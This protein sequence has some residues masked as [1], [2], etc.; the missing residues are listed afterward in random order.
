MRRSRRETRTPGRY[1]IFS[2]N[3]GRTPSNA[4]RI[5]AFWSSVSGSRPVFTWRDVADRSRP[6]A[7]P[8]IRMTFFAASSIPP[9]SFSTN[10]TLD[11]EPPTADW[12]LLFTKYYQLEPYQY[13]VSGVLQNKNVTALQVNGVPTADAGWTSAPFNTEIN[14]LGSD[15]KDY[16]TNLGAYSIVTDTTYFVKDIPGN[17]WK[18]VFTGY[19]GSA[20]GD[21]S[22]NQELVSSVGV[23]ELSVQQGS[24]ITYPNPVSNGLAQLIVDVPAHEGT[25]RV[26]SAT[27][28]QMIQQQWTGLSGL[29]ARTIDVSGLAKGMYIVRFDAANTST[30]GKLVIE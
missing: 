9:W 17:I 15:W 29:N 2:T 3:L 16:D 6:S 20:N 1:S 11:R 23:H 21:M 24:L 4:S 5:A 27:G 30:N 8:P 22:F 12:D 7:V 13:Y 28:Q 25:I 18:I 10:A 26:F 14:V 19:G